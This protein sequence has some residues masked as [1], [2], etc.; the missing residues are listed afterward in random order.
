MADPTYP[1]APAPPRAPSD[2]DCARARLE[3]LRAEIAECE[4]LL[5]EERRV[6]EV[7]RVEAEHVARA[8]AEALRVAANERAALRAFAED[9]VRVRGRL[10]GWGDIKLSMALEALRPCPHC[11]GRGY[12]FDLHDGVGGRRGLHRRFE[13]NRVLAREAAGET[14]TAAERA[15][16]T[17]CRAGGKKGI[18]R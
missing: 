18:V 3:A 6:A 15:E 10:E 1:P 8:R 4:A 13:R 16:A 7:A 12:T 11:H 9:A 5:A 14:L 17:A 2:L